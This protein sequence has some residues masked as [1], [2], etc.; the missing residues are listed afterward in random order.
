MPKVYPLSSN[1]IPRDPK[2]PAPQRVKDQLGK[3]WSTATALPSY[4]WKMIVAIKNAIVSIL[5]N[6][7]SNQVKRIQNVVKPVSPSTE[8]PLPGNAPPSPNEIDS[9]SDSDSVS[10]VLIHSDSSE[11]DSDSNVSECN[12]ENDFEVIFRQE[13]QEPQARGTSPRASSGLPPGHTNVADDGNCLF[14]AVFVGMAW[15]YQHDERVLKILDCDYDLENLKLGT[16]IA[17]E[18]TTLPALKLREGAVKYIKKHRN[19][20]WVELTLPSNFT[21]HQKSHKQKIDGLQGNIKYYQEMAT[22]TPEEENFKKGK[23]KEATEGIE[24]L[25]KNR[26]SDIEDY[27]NLLAQDGTYGDTVCIEAISRMFDL[28]IH[29]HGSS[30]TYNEKPGVTPITLVYVDGNH[31]RCFIEPEAR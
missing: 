31:Y 21:D 2:L 13:S 24:Y 7:S 10:M 6:S 17:S 29:L 8:L 22:Q 30:T 11:S 23:I 15:L 5:N 16:K 28:P 18:I 25:E 19:E 26:I 4:L 12:S 1:N 27:L 20:E 3:I 14:A 9:N